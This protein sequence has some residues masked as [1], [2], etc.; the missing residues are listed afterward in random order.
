[1]RNFTTRLLPILLLAGVPLFAQGNK[2]AIENDQV[3]VLV[4]TDQPHVK[5][6]LHKHDV[7]RVMIYLNAGKQEIVTEGKKADVEYKAGEA[8]WSPAGGMHTAEV[9]S[10]AP[11]KIVEVEIKKPGD[12]AKTI[13]TPLDP[14]KIDK[15]DYRVEFENSQ[16]RVVRV[17]MAA[18]RKVPEHEHQ[19]NRVVV[20]LTDQ[21]GTMTTADGQTTKA[22]H[23]P[24][25][26]SWGGPVKHREENLM[27]KPFE[28]VVI[29][30]K[31]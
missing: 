14:P 31:N 9:T 24:G 1:M 2:P 13:T 21:D 17:K 30:L 26:A 5:T 10:A 6:S 29:E 12:P 23:K 28:A 16:V 3:R 8:K 19:L 27:D 15:Q 11:L 4:V 22:Q 18:H 25:E 20:Y 7:N